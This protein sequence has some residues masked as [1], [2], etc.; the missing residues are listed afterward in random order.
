MWVVT[1]A[2]QPIESSSS[3]IARPSAPPSAGSVP[4]PISSSMTRE[5]S[6]AVATIFEIRRMWLEKVERDC[7]R[8][9][10]SP[11]SERTSSKIGSCDP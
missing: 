10:S 11:M 9:C 7:S 4:A 1:I 5:C 6:V 8:L 2:R 3:R